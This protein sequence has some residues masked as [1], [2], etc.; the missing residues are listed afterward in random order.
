MKTLTNAAQCAKLIRQELKKAFP[1]IKFSVKS[2][3]FAGGDA[4]DIRYEDG[5]TDTKV[6]ELVSKFRAGDYDCMEEMY[7][8]KNTRK[9]IPTVKFVQVHRTMSAHIREVLATEL[10]LK[11]NVSVEFF[12]D[13][14]FIVPNIN[15]R[16]G[17]IIQ[18]EF[19]KRN[20]N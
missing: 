6:E 8:Y 14:N 7:V 17:C 15:Q 11:F 18:K 20:F 13:S 4:V 19:Y 1:N 3:T 2:D 9:D 5:I 12:R 10:A 16:S